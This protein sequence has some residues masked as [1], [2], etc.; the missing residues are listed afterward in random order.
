MCPSPVPP[1]KPRWLACPA[2]RE[3]TDAYWQAVSMCRSMGIELELHPLVHSPELP[4]QRLRRDGRW[5]GLVLWPDDTGE[6]LHRQAQAQGVHVRR[7]SAD[8]HVGLQPWSVD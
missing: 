6:R 2:N 5:C 7:F 8:P 3:Q 4:W 1:F